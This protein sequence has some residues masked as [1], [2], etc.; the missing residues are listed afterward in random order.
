MEVSKSE[1]MIAHLTSRTNRSM[2]KEELKAENVKLKE[3]V[4][5]LTELLISKGIDPI[6]SEVSQADKSSMFGTTKLNFLH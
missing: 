6:V 3:K 5:M 2:T 4:L 1:D